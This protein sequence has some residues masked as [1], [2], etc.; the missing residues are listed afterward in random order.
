MSTEGVPMARTRIFL[1][2]GVVVLALL[3][4]MRLRG[5][6][7]SSP[8]KSRTAIRK[9][10]DD[11]VDAWNQAD[12]EGFMHGYW[13]DQDSPDQKLTFFSGGDTTSGWQ[14]TYERYRRRYQGEGQEMGTLTFSDL[15]ILP[16]GGDN[17]VVRGHWKVEKKSETVEG[18]FTLLFQKKAGHWY[19]V[20]DH[21]SK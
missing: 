7:N 10:L 13:Q 15:D 9:V 11:Q 21:T 19:I 16:L 18:L 4:V 20:H 2:L 17:A 5:D 8:E 14:A 3:V 1:A 12:L 6:G